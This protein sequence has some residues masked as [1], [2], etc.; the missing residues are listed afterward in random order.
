M[1]KTRTHIPLGLM[2]CAAL[3]VPFSRANAC[4]ITKLD[5]PSELIQQADAIYLVVA[6]DFAQSPPVGR[7]TAG[8]VRF[9]IAETLKGAERSEIRI[10]GFFTDADDPNDHPVPYE[11][12]RPEGRHGNCYAEAYREGRTYLL[13]VKGGTP[14]WS[15]LAPVNEQVG[16]GSDAWVQWVREHLKQQQKG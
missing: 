1:N 2:L 15:H 11:F 3:V 4:S 16:S 9:T 13:F 6:R 14:Y 5:T 10:P 8:T 12:V 7:H